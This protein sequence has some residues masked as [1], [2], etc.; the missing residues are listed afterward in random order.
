MVQ[1]E[2]VEVAEVQVHQVRVDLT[3]VQVHQGH[4]VVVEHRVLQVQVVRLLF[5][6]VSGLV[7]AVIFRGM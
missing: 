7:L 1:A 2:Q 5:G 3:V 4:Q 6:G